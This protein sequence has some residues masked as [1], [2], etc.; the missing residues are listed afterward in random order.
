MIWLRYAARTRAWTDRT[1]SISV[2]L[3]GKRVIPKRSDI[4]EL[5]LNTQV[6]FSASIFGRRTRM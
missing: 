6:L 4:T 1:E 3:S 5:S 2:L